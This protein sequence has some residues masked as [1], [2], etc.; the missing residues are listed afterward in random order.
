MY[1]VMISFLV[2]LRFQGGWVRLLFWKHPIANKGIGHEHR[3]RTLPQKNSGNSASHAGMEASGDAN[4]HVE[5]K[6][7]TLPAHFF[8]S[9]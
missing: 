9:D 6:A 8:F 3:F 7:L 2:M 5:S 1:I 4:F